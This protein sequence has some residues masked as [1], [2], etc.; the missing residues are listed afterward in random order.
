MRMRQAEAAARFDPGTQRIRHKGLVFS[1]RIPPLRAS[2]IKPPTAGRGTHAPRQ[3]RRR[4]PQPFGRG[5]E[6][7]MVR[8]RYEKLVGGRCPDLIRAYQRKYPFHRAT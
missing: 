3:S 1:H 4:G 2:G 5:A 8:H 7:A 6:A